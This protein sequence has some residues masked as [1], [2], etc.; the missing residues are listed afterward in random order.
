VTNPRPARA[1]AD[2]EAAMANAGKAMFGKAAF[3]LLAVL[4]MQNAP[5]AAAAA[6][7][8]PAVVQLKPGAFA[9]WAAGEFTRDGKPIDAPR[10]TV[11]MAAPLAIMVHQVSV[12]EYRRCVAEKA[13][14]PLSDE[15]AGANVPAVMVS[16]YDAHAYAA[17]LSNKLGAHYR[18]PTDEEW[19]YAAGSR[20]PDEAPLGDADA[21]ARWVAQ[22]DRETKA[23]PIDPRPQPIG[24]YGANEN[25]LL[26][27]AGNVWEWTDSC[28]TRTV[29]DVAGKPLGKGTVNCGVRI[30][31]GRHRAYISD[32][33]RD[34]RGGG[35]A[36]GIPP[37]NLGFRLV[38]EEKRVWSLF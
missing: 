37:S 12:D 19:T 15:Q 10:R 1:L 7:E 34:P 13:C 29:V 23:A 35:C 28:Y 32:F 26:D 9:Y 38:R 17:W 22:Y 5:A 21:V 4:A 16:W 25:G 24:H 2:S 33:I 36:A 30:A 31:E 18:L 8:P 14:S 3:G 6:I 11:Q 27:L 20:A